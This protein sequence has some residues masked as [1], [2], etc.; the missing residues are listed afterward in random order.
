MENFLTL[1]QV[2]AVTRLSKAT[3]SRYRAEGLFPAPIKI[4]K[5]RVVWLAA[6]VYEYIND[7]VKISHSI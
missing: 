2:I 4:G 5:R 3:I 6:D 1:S 7:R